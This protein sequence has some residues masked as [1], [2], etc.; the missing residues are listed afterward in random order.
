MRKMHAGKTLKMEANNKIT[1]RNE[2]LRLVIFLGL[3]VS[4][5]IYIS[6]VLE[7]KECRWMKGKYY[8]GTSGC[9]I[10]TLGTSHMLYGVYPQVMN[11][12]VE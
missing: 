8:A 3:M 1:F 9:S 12:I 10:I 6:L 2:I 4:I 11:E 7:D 5:L